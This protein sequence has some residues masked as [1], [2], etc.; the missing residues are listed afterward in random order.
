MTRKTILNESS[1]KGYFFDA[2]LQLSSRL[3]GGGG[4]TNPVANFVS[5][6]LQRHIFM[7]WG[8]QSPSRTR[9]HTR[10]EI[11]NFFCEPS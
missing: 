2:V 10:L 6:L 7:W 5:S 4:A 11:A 1:G 8:I 9:V 3:E